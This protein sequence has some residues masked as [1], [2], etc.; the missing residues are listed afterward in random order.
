MGKTSSSLGAFSANFFL[1]AFAAAFFPDAPPP[2]CLFLFD[3]PLTTVSQP[4]LAA[5]Y[6]AVEAILRFYY[7]LSIFCKGC[8]VIDK[9]CPKLFRQPFKTKEEY[10][11]YATSFITLKSV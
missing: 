6:P 11:F 9:V 2:P 8:S 4:G 5:E 1:A 3:F 7:F 10:Q